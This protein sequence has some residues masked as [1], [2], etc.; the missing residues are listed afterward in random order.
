MK[1]WVYDSCR[2]KEKKRKG[3]KIEFRNKHILHPIIITRYLFIR[4]EA[5][6]FPYLTKRTFPQ[7][8]RNK[9]L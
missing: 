2:R 5:R 8:Q 4:I 6:N 7:E 9:R 3:E 1:G